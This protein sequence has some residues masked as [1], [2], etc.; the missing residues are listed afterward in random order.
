[1]DEFTSILDRALARQVCEQLSLYVH[2]QGNALR[3]LVVATV[4]EDVAS[5]L[6]VDWI[7]DSRRGSLQPAPASGDAVS[8][9]APAEPRKLEVRLSQADGKSSKEVAQLLEPPVLRL[10]VRRLEPHQ[11][12]RQ[13]F[14]EHFLEHH[15]MRGEVPYCFWG[16]VVRDEGTGRYVAFHALANQPGPVAVASLTARAGW[17]SCQSTRASESAPPCPRA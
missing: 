16:V 7:L 15:Y 12:S 5:W 8:G 3:P 1:M 11:P 13:V 4:H 10:A 2:A 17:W 9:G 6:K 14:H